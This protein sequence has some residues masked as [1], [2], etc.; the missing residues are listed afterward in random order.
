MEIIDNGAVP[1]EYETP[2]RSS[3]TRGTIPVSTRS[4]VE[5]SAFL[6]TFRELFAR[7]HNPF[8]LWRRSLE[9]ER[10]R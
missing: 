7:D 4:E 8:A 2:E 6:Q 10:S 1:K 5:S 3:D 9:L